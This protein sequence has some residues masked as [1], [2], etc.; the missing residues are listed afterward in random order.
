MFIPYC[1][2]RKPKAMKSCPKKKTAIFFKINE[3][4]IKFGTLSNDNRF[5]WIIEGRLSDI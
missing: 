5:F 1:I 3:V 2:N 4:N